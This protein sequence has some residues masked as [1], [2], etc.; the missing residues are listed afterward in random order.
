MKLKKYLAGSL[1]ALLSLTTACTDEQIVETGQGNGT[2]QPLPEGAVQFKIDGINTG[3]VESRATTGT[4]IATSQE[5]RVDH[6][7]IYIFG[8]EKEGATQDELTFREYWTSEKRADYV[9]DTEKKTF[10]L[11]GMGKYYTATVV[12]PAELKTTYFMFVTNEPRQFNAQP[13]FTGLPA[14]MTGTMTELTKLYK[15]GDEHIHTG[16]ELEGWTARD[17]YYLAFSDAI[18]GVGVPAAYG[19]TV[20]VTLPCDQPLFE[21][22]NDYAG[23]IPG[24]RETLSM[25]GWSRDAVTSDGQAMS[26]TLYRNVARLDVSVDGGIALKSLK[27]TNISATSAHAKDQYFLG[28][29]FNY[30]LPVTDVQSTFSLMKTND[31][32]ELY[33]PARSYCYPSLMTNDD[34]AE[35]KLIGEQADGT[36]FSI[37][38]VDK[39]TKQPLTI[40]NNHRYTIKIRR[41]SDNSIDANIIVEAWNVGDVIDVDLNG[42]DDLTP[43]PALYDA[44]NYE[45]A[46]W[47]STSKVTCMLSDN[48]TL[49]STNPATYPWLRFDLRQMSSLGLRMYYRDSETDFPGAFFDPTMKV[50]GTV[51]SADGSMVRH[52]LMVTFPTVNT[53]WLKLQN[54]FDPSLNYVVKVETGNTEAT[55]TNAKTPALIAFAETNVSDAGTALINFPSG[56]FDGPYCQ[57]VADWSTYRGQAGANHA[58][59]TVPGYA[60]PTEQQLQ[61]IAPDDKWGRFDTYNGANV[62]KTIINNDLTVYYSGSPLDRNVVKAVVDRSQAGTDLGTAPQYV[63]VEATLWH[64]DAR[65][66]LR[67]NM[68]NVSMP[69]TDAGR[70]TSYTAL[71]DLFN[72]G[73]SVSA[74]YTRFFP[75]AGAETA[76]LGAGTSALVFGP[77]EVKYV[78]AYAGT[79]FIRPV[80]SNGVMQIPARTPVLI[81]ERVINHPVETITDF[82]VTT[83]DFAATA[84]QNALDNVPAGYWKLP[85][86]ADINT[87]AHMQLTAIP[88]TVTDPDFLKVFPATVTRA[89]EGTASYWL[90][91]SYNDNEAYCLVRTGNQASVISKPKTEDIGVRYIKYN[92]PEYAYGGGAPSIPVDLGTNADGMIRKPVYVAPVNANDN[93]QF[94]YANFAT[95]GTGLCPAGWNV[96]TKEEAMSIFGLTDAEWPYD[97]STDILNAWPAGTY[98]TRDRADA[99]RGWSYK[100][101]ADGRVSVEKLNQETGARARCVKIKEQNP[102]KGEE[103]K[104]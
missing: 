84:W 37:P 77:D 64:Y 36:A 82:G 81:P 61:C 12:V 68:V 86:K 17:S 21:M 9:C 22:E 76:Y 29:P 102:D 32:G 54:N 78:A 57:P 66:Y 75:A 39:D 60:I 72:N 97:V 3:A 25:V 104:R 33:V 92:T 58:L 74:G 52:E 8:S 11:K 34:Y 42:G 35:V 59:I 89:G 7:S 55:G 2:G 67:I 4:V 5:N 47:E 79:G 46:Q 73:Q 99:T 62:V 71:T 100:I 10:A 94:K 90:A 41:S 88:V 28:F 38:F 96:P 51:E 103:I 91:D 85:A 70:L 15:K 6:L 27:L 44:S 87:M 24:Q 93:V 18:N 40:E 83:G 14:T 48:Y 45:Y 80:M 16:Y 63:N 65:G 49:N 56:G 31:A 1:L 50:H 69:G 30:A 53:Q 95:D 26:V 98:W 101:G 19:Y 13:L 23:F 20:P 43:A